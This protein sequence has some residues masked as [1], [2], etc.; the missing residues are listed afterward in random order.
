MGEARGCLSGPTFNRSITIR[1]A[2]LQITPGGGVPLP[3]ELDHRMSL[4]RDPLPRSFFLVTNWRAE[5]NDWWAMLEHYR[6]RGTF[7]D[8]PGDFSAVIGTRLL[9]KLFAANEASTLLKLL[10]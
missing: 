5:Q 9:A 2:D 10:A 3:R 4:M 1:Q 7:K 6:K 8:R